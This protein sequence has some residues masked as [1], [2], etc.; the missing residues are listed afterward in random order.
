M[1]IWRSTPKEERR[2]KMAWAESRSLGGIRVCNG[3]Y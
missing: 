3:Y 1:E 2:E